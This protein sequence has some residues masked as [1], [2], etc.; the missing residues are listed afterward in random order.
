MI[1]QQRCLPGESQAPTQPCF[2]PGEDFRGGLSEGAERQGEDERGEGGAEAAAGEA[3][4]A[5]GGLQQPGEQRRVL[6]G[7]VPVS[8]EVTVPSSEQEMR[9]DGG[10]REVVLLPL[11]LARAGLGRLKFAWM[12]DTMHPSSLAQ[13]G[14]S[15]RCQHSEPDVVVP[16]GRALGLSPPK[17]L[18]PVLLLEV[19]FGDTGA[20]SPAG[21][22]ASGW[23]L[24]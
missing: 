24:H 16:M 6:R 5:A 10:G 15:E 21:H 18:P 3:A 2:P 12:G 1:T 19:W 11:V 22:R 9:R 8:V 17:Y 13:E 4:E 23:A 20:G 7:Q 14:V